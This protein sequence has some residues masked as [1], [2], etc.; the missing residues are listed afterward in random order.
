MK[1]FLFAS[2]NHVTGLYEN[3][4][5]YRAIVEGEFEGLDAERL[6]RIMH[7]WPI[8]P[9]SVYGARKAFGEALGRYALDRNG[10]LRWS[11]EKPRLHRVALEHF[12]GRRADD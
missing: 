10:C 2:S 1:R 6:D 8:R 5:P 7:E 4:R 12:I 9:D 3:D 11:S